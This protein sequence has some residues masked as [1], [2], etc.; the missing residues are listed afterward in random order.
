MCIKMLK[1]RLRVDGQMGVFFGGAELNINR[2][3]ASDHSCH[4]CQQAC[5]KILIS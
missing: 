1:V 5:P 4:L 2:V 3:C